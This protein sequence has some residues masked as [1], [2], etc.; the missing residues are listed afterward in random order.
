MSFTD[1][2]TVLT[3]ARELAGRGQY[4]EALERHVWFHEHALDRDDN[5]CG[6]RLSYA[7]SDWVQLGDV[8]PPARDALVETRNR[9]AAALKSGDWSQE[10]FH[11]VAR[12]NQQ[13]GAEEETASLFLDLHQSDPVKASPF[14]SD[15][16]PGLLARGLHAV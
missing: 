11:D 7:L 1:P 4:Q 14:Y 9:A 13:L 16:E 15:A 5:L 3:E 10:R 6:V 8:Y 2:R 12:I